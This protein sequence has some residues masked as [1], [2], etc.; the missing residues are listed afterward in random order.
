MTL[1]VFNAAIA[2]LQSPKHLYA[3]RRRNGRMEVI[4]NGVAS[5][6]NTDPIP[7]ELVGNLV[8]ITTVIQHQQGPHIKAIY[9]ID[10]DD[11]V[12]V[13]SYGQ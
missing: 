10:V 9:L 5:T 4:G 3:F 12:E 1:P 11:I 7:W 8:K 13:I 2:A 6:T